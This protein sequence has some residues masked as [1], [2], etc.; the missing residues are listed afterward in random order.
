MSTSIVRFRNPYIK[1]HPG[2][3]CRRMSFFL[4]FSGPFG[5]LCVFCVGRLRSAGF[6]LN[7]F[8]SGSF[9]PAGSIPSGFCSGNLFQSGSIPSCFCSGRLLPVTRVPC[10]VPLQ[11]F[12]FLRLRQTLALAE[13]LHEFGS[14]KEGAWLRRR[15][16]LRT[17]SLPHPPRRPW[18]LRS[19]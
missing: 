7:G 1:G 4:F 19:P 2:R 18:H 11:L 14:R 6:I 16:P 15:P 13:D 5:L 17:S 8:C 9:F 3:S 10:F 12:L